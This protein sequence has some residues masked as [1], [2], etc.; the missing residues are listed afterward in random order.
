MTENSKESTQRVVKALTI[1]QPWASLIAHGYKHVET[2]SWPTTHRG[3]L[4]IHAGR[5]SFA[6]GYD[7]VE[8]RL[9]HARDDKAMEAL[10]DLYRSSFPLGAIVAVAN[11]TDCVQVE[12]DADMTIQL[13][14]VEHALGD[15]TPRRYAWVLEDVRAIDPPLA[16][17]GA[18]G[19]WDVPLDLIEPLDA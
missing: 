12:H 13:S 18:Q 16:C 7:V 1:H 2:R 14:A 4:A 6:E 3:P 8:P 17:R 19:L 5:R 9:K 11:V 10:F 15:Y